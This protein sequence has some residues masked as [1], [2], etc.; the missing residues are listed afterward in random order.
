M[1]QESAECLRAALRMPEEEKP[2]LGIVLGTGWDQA[3]PDL[4]GAPVL[5]LRKIPGFSFLER[6]PVKEHAREFRYRNVDGKRVLILSGPVRL[7]EDP[8]HPEEIVPMVRLQMELMIAFGIPRFI[9]TTDAT[10]VNGKVLKVGDVLVVD[11]FVTAWA[12]PMPLYSNERVCP[13]ECLSLELR[14]VAEKVMMLGESLSLTGPAVKSGIFLMTP[15][16]H[17]ETRADLK[18]FAARTSAVGQGLLPEACIASLHQRE[19]LALALVTDDECQEKRAVERGP[20]L[21][22]ALRRIIA[23]F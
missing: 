14:R 9:L 3:L 18:T 2:D 5:P 6:M 23:A 21:N 13:S 1:A 20:F 16:P 19:V 11:D 7:N 22:R 4:E 8:R 12:I 15:G 17:Q 10:S